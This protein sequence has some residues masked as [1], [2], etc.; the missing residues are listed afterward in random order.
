MRWE[1]AEGNNP[2]CLKQAAGNRLR[3]GKGVQVRKGASRQVATRLSDR[4]RKAGTAYMRRKLGP[5]RQKGL[6]QRH[7]DDLRRPRASSHY[8]A[9]SA[10]LPSDP[11][12]KINH[13]RKKSHRVSKMEPH[14][15][16]AQV[17]NG[18]RASALRGG[19]ESLIKRCSEV[20]H[21]G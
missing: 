9:Q 2:N 21:R 19:F 18:A 16:Q 8:D 13:K 15:R 11:G 7:G 12:C 4:F 10:R 6:K 5:H 20:E 3:Q 1:R 17:W 14:T